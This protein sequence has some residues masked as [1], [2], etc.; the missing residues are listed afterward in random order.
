MC[1]VFDIIIGG[2]KKRQ[3]KTQKLMPLLEPNLSLSFVTCQS[4]THISVAACD[5]LPN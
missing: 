5:P 3:K 2:N 4:K 1:L